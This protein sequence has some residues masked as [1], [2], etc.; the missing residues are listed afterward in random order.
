MPSVEINSIWKVFILS[1]QF[2]IK[3][4]CVCG[5]LEQNPFLENLKI[6]KALYSTRTKSK[7]NFNP[8]SGSLCPNQSWCN[9]DLKFFLQLDASNVDVTRPLARYTKENS[10]NRCKGF[11]G[12]PLRAS[13]EKLLAE[14]S[15][16]M[17]PYLSTYR[18]RC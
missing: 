8:T 9:E 2:G 11:S 18:T 6:V 15:R 3:C 10:C 4:V 7:M 1:M 13:R 12:K 16:T 14:K 17:M 5:G